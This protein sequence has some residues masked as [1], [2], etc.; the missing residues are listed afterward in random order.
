MTFGDRV[1]CKYQQNQTQFVYDGMI[2]NFLPLSH[3]THSFSKLLHSDLSCHHE[4]Y[5]WKF[6]KWYSHRAYSHIPPPH[7]T[8]CPVCCVGNC[9]LSYSHIP[10]HYSLPS[11]VRRQLSLIIFTHPPTHYSLPS[12][13]RRQLSLII[14][15]HP[16]TLQ[17][18]QCGV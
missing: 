5:L 9:H 3:R 12:A 8:A 10:P 11:V 13:V 16:P 7:T 14:F 18:A 6:Q 15:T 2:F 17:L 4:L 1:L